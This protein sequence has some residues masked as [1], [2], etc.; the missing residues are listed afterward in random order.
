M[1]RGEDLAGL[2]ALDGLLDAALLTGGPGVIAELFA[3]LQVLYADV[4]VLRLYAS[5]ARGAPDDSRP[6]HATHQSQ[7][8]SGPWT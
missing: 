8:H 3:R 5:S 1:V 4:G 7:S 2:K 6:T